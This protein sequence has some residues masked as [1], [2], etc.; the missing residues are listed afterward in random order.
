MLLILVRI[1]PPEDGMSRD[2]VLV[3]LRRETESEL[4][5]LVQMTDS[6][7]PTKVIVGE[8]NPAEVVAQTVKALAADIIVT[9][10]YS[11]RQLCQT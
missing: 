10:P 3:L 8:G 2:H 1:I 4:N 9:C 6:K 7:I 5:Q 11:A